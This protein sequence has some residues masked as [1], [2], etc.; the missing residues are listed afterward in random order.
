METRVGIVVAVL[1][2]LWTSARAQWWSLPPEAFPPRTDTVSLYIVGDIM[3]HA[4]MTKSAFRSGEA[5]YSTFF[6]HLEG[7]IAAADI[8]IG[9][10]EF[11]LAGKPYTGYP[12]FSGP[13]AYALYL[14]DIGFDVLLTA[15]NHILDKGSEGLDKT[16][17]E[18][19]RFKLLYTGIASTE[20]QDSLQNP[21][22][23]RC[24][25]LHIA[26]LNFTYGT[27]SG[28]SSSWPKVNYMRKEDIL[29]TLERCENADLVIAF[30]H[31]GIEYAHRHSAAQE[32]MAKF[33]VDHG[34]D[35][36]VGAHPH[37]VQ[38][39]DTLGGVHVLYSVGNAVSN[40][41]DLPARLELGVRVR[42]L[43]SNREEARILDVEP[44]YLWCTKPGMLEDS[45]ATIP[46]KEFLGK[47]DLW[48]QPA[49]YDNMVRTY[50][51][52]QKETAIYEKDHHPGSH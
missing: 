18:L 5:D 24:K 36:I 1:L 30:P 8:A 41:N 21:L 4:P 45:Y 17:R 37:V 7:R 48:K 27:N 38:D 23:L 10:L 19:D 9:N 43:S 6:R 51:K 12:A 33:L 39:R 32:E 49:D 40:Q 46:V 44:E 28:S 15:N 25:G 35:L 2:S 42:I 34:V 13:L 47:R 3:S 20:R 14:E 52:V 22:I 29:R 11:P 26:V 16:I 50:E 31:W